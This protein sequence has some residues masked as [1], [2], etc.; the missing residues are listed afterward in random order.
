MQHIQ[1]RH[2]GQAKL[3]LNCSQSV[4]APDRTGRGMTCAEPLDRASFAN[5]GDD[6]VHG[7]VYTKL[8]H[9]SRPGPELGATL[10]TALVRIIIKMAELLM[11]SATI[12]SGAYVDPR[13]APLL[14]ALAVRLAA[15]AL[16]R[17]RSGV[18]PVVCP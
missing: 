10:S 15:V 16:D 18:S 14:D 12:E 4:G 8:C 17:M 5:R 7:R 6:K 9:F 11:N 13:T 1:G 2:Y 3:S